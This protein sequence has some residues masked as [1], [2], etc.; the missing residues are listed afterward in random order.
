MAKIQHL[1][2]HQEFLFIA[3]SS[4]PVWSPMEPF[5]IYRANPVHNCVPCR[6]PGD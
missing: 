5:R 4:R 1:L 3:A 2:Y 6:A